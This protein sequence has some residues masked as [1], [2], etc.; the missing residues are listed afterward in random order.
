MG[1]KT[2][3]KPIDQNLVI[4]IGANHHNSLGILRSLG[5][6][7]IRPW[8]ILVA[9]KETSYVSRCCY[10]GKL[11]CA[12]DSHE[13]ISFLIDERSKFKKKP[14]VI[15]GYDGIA[16][17]LDLYYNALKD[18]YF[19][20]G[21]EQEG[22]LTHYM[23]KEVMADLAR[24]VGLNT[25][26]TWVLDK[27]STFTDVEYPCIIKPIM[28]KNGK[29]SDIEVCNNKE[30]L[31]TALKKGFC[32]KF[33]VQKYIKKDFEYQI[34]GLSLN[35]GENV[36]I[37]G[38][39]HCIRPCPRTNTGYLKYESLDGFNAPIKQCQ[40]FL[41]EVGYSGLFSMEFLRDKQGKDFFMET[42]FRNDGNAICVTKAG[43]NLP[44]IWYL[45][46]VGSDWSG[47]I[48]KIQAPR[49]TIYVMPEFDDWGAV[50]RGE[51]TVLRYLKD[52][53]SAD[54]FVEFDI[55]DIK[56]FWYLVK[57]RIIRRFKMIFGKN[58]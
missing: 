53:L 33:Q 48:T 15:A 20:P 14:I 35:G 29:K 39:S 9:P 3:N 41:R 36:I 8:F 18:Y 34:I 38:V 23:D 12:K 24:N 50:H 54:T 4:V 44:Y 58:G 30:E 17:E 45:S 1:K 26:E 56:P 13:C 57:I 32:T 19:L 47:E 16:S 27:E 37:P 21:C 42:N 10:I 51:I 49:K 55:T 7:G 43:F 2:D 31:E 11:I 52:C 28:S 46:G 22:K 5:Y 25:P 40:S 6:K